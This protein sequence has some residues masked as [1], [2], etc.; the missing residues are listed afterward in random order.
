MK[1]P[2]DCSLLQIDCFSISNWCT[3]NDL[4]LNASNVSKTSLSIA[5]EL[6]LILYAWCNDKKADKIAIGYELYGSR[7]IPTDTVMDLGSFIWI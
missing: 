2:Q 7:I 5:L 4:K 3:E 1:F 6:S